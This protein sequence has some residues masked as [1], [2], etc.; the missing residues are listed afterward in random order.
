MAYA[1]NER[2]VIEVLDEKKTQRV[3]QILRP[4]FYPSENK[5]RVEPFP[6]CLPCMSWGYGRTPFNLD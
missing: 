2:L 6:V 1:S 3:Y 4:K 5:N